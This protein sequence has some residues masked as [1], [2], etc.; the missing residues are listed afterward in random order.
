M[1][2]IL[3]SDEY[4]SRNSMPTNSSAIRTQT[5]SDYPAVGSLGDINGDKAGG[6]LIAPEY[7]LV[8][9]HSVVGL[10][11]GQIT[12]TI[13]GVK[14]RIA[15]V[16]VNP[17][18]DPDLVG[19]EDG[20][21]IAI[22]KLDMPVTNI[23]PIAITGRSPR[24]G[25]SLKLVGFGEHDKDAFGTKRVGSTPPVDELGR[26]AFRWTFTSDLQ[27]T[28]DV[29]DS[30]SPL[31]VNIGGV[32]QLIGIVS[33]GTSASGGIG[34]VA[35]NMRVD[36]Y[37]PW[38]RSVVSSIQADDLRDVPSI[39]VEDTELFLDENAGLIVVGFEVSANDAVVFSVSTDRP[40]LF[41]GLRVDYTGDSNGN[42][43]FE[44]AVNQ[45]GTATITL[46]AYAGG[47][48]SFQTI[49][50][51]IE[52]RNDPPTIDPVEPVVLDVSAG[53]QSIALTGI[54]AGIGES[55][56]VRLSIL[57]ASPIT[58]F[59]SLSIS[60]G[61]FGNSEGGS[62]EAVDPA[63]SFTPKAGSL[64]SGQISV[65][66]RD[67]GPDGVFNS[68][69]DAT[70][71]KSIVVITSLNKSPAFNEIAKQRLLLSAGTQVVS[72]SGIGD[73]D[74]GTQSLRFTVDSSNPTIADFDVLY[75]DRNHAATG[76]LQV[77]PFKAGSTNVTVTVS[78]PG[79]DGQFDTLDDRKFS[80]TFVL[81]TVTALHPWQNPVDPLNV[82]ALGNVSAFDV[83]LLIN[84]IN[85]GEGGDL[86]NRARTNE[87]YYDVTGDDLLSPLD[88]LVVINAI[89]RAENGEG[90]DAIP[91]ALKIA[92]AVPSIG[93]SIQQ[94]SQDLNVWSDLNWL[95]DEKE[96]IGPRLH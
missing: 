29:G 32:D 53:P 42:V 3:A 12:F 62:G 16:I 48:T 51:M 58:F 83:L 92:Q 35:T 2:S 70:T 34:D 69:D 46:T 37:L 57:N 24:L 13:G 64:G 50:V 87:P 45:R 17:G 56:N 30:G 14:H 38:I 85:R 95:W 39:Q 10:P 77:I 68:S 82:D 90:E 7:V 21:D 47:L 78:D 19:L 11:P 9:A 20:N 94:E 73:G 41:K 27:N 44:S 84:A 71:T 18:Y 74:G 75:D 15:D 89:N 79:A 93:R 28:S 86:S 60:Q 66:I 4:Y 80:R 76:Q 6:T 8:A 43:V 55:G 88:V 96:V 5:T 1:M 61:T 26:T 81:E 33:G 63:L 72:M 54:T 22:L 36:S 65:E 40:E 23:Q 91:A 52:E 25:E 59:S 31:L 49:Q 67:A